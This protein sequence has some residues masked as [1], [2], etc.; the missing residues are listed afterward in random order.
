MN[1]KSIFLTG[2]TSFHGRRMA[3]EFVEKGYE[4][5]GLIRH[6][7]NRDFKLDGVT[8]YKG[9]I[10]NSSNFKIFKEIDIDIFVHLAAQTP[11][12][13][14]FGHESE[15]LDANF[16]GAVNMAELMVKYV[17]NLEKFVMASSVEVYGNQTHFPIAETQPVNPASPYGVAKASAEIYLNYLH[18]GYNFPCVIVRSANTYGREKSYLFVIEHIIRD[19][20]SGNKMVEMGL[21]YPVRD[22]LHVDDE[23]EAYCKLIESENPKILGETFNT[24]TGVGISINDL[25]YKILDKVGIPRE[26]C[27][28]IWDRISPRPYEIK[29]LIIDATK[30]TG[31]TGWVPKYSLDEGLEK[32]I[33]VWRKRL[34]LA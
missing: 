18:K 30:L 11:V 23:I 21:P 26:N 5:S 13:Y 25:F 7:A 9:D 28:P 27:T 22:F 15:V 2:L 29:K 1:V 19:V 33:G 16:Y 14:S 24:G 4:V 20:L 34:G 6:V 31:A 8:V 12:A 3:K 32:T 10:R 17:P